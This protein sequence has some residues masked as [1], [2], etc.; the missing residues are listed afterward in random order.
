M[1]LTRRSALGLSLGIGGAMV[2]AVAAPRLSQAQGARVLR[3]VPQADLTNFDP[4]LTTQ[5]VVRNASLL[6][7]DQLY[8]IDSR[9]EPQPQMAE[10]HEVSADGLTWT[11]RLRQ[12]L[13]FHDG[14][15]VLAKDAVASIRRWMPRDVM[16]MRLRAVLD[17]IAV[18]DDRSFRIRLGQPFPKLLFA[19]AKSTTLLLCIMPERIASTD[20]FKAITEYVGSGP[21]LFKRDEWVAGAKAVFQRFDGYAPR[22]GTSDWL[23]G[24][25]RVNFDRVE[26]ITMPDAG[27]AAAALQAG[28]VDWWEQAVND[29]SPVL[30]RNRQVKVDV[31]DPL[32]NVGLL[33][34]NHL[35]APFTDPRARQALQWLVN[36]EDYMGAVAGDDTALW[37]T[38]P[39][40][41]TPGTPYYTEVGGERLRGARRVDEAKRLLEAA[42]YKGEAIVLPVATDVPNVKNQGDVTAD[43]LKRAGVNVDMIAMDW[44]T[45][46]ARTNNKGVPS[47][48]GWHLSH[49]WVAGA[50]CVTPAGHK[51]LDAGGGSSLSGWAKSDEVQGA[52]SEW[53]TLTDPAAAKASMDKIN[54]MSM[55]FV[56]VI[57]TGF[58]VGSTAYRTSV[59]GMAKSPYPQFWGVSKS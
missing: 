41:F 23:A 56:T 12:G 45:Q 49:T 5:Q 6:V 10:G 37:K 3:F 14:E 24:G 38:M 31:A 21:M 17:E 13:K 57:P 52:I 59:S 9:F 20:A 7:W 18:V 19:F 15:P 48:G 8:G 34:V 29:L 46:S 44:G 55:D 39:S 54:R 33:K 35:H 32:G 53:F 42:G 4:V 22:E 51:A 40:F 27:T 1:T 58:F 43:M 16:G 25:K 30:K 47:Q 26:W 11:F 2:G 36:Q 50:E 28:E